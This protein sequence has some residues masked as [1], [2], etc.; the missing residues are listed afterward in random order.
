VKRFLPAK[1]HAAIDFATCGLWFVGPE[2]FRMA[3][4]PGSTLGPKLYGT[5]VLANSILT[6]FG[7]AE[8]L[9]Y[10]GLRT[11]SMRTHLRI[12]LVG[13]AAVAAAPFVT[14]SWRRGWNYWAPHLAATGLVW[15]SAFTTE[16]P[17]ED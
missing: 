16:I 13:S 2:V 4:Q 8:K 3:W 11:W 14:G 15:L 10:G 12:D 9:E 6:D 1:V 5:S 7:P 17:G